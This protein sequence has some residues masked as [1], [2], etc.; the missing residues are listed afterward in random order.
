MNRVKVLNQD[1]DVGEAVDNGILG[2]VRK[3]WVNI[4]S[5]KITRCN[6]KPGKLPYRNLVWY[7]EHALV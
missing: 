4:K 2:M 3:I 5:T 1:W 7:L 6:A